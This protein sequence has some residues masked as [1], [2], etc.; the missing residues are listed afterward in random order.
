MLAQ[1]LPSKSH[2]VAMNSLY[3]ILS[4]WIDFLSMWFRLNL[5]TIFQLN[6]RA[7]ILKIHLIL[8]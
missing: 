7:F 8:E 4:F 5:A 1:K 6:L 3:G 2:V